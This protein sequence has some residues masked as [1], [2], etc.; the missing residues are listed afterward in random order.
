MTKR[1][2]LLI[3]GNGPAAH[4]LITDLCALQALPES[5]G[6]IGEESRT[7]YNRILLSPLLAAQIDPAQLELHYPPEAQNAVEQI[8]DA[9]VVAINAQLQSVTTESGE[10]FG[11]EQLVIATGARPVI[12]DL[13]GVRARGV[14]AFRSW[15]DV[16]RMQQVAARG[17]RAVVVGGGFLGL[18]AAEGLRKLGMSVTLVHRSG[19]LLNRQLDPQAAALLR[20]EM[21][22]RGLEVRTQEQLQSIQ[23][24]YSQLESVTLSNGERLSA[25]LLVFATGI[26]PNAQLAQTGGL[27]HNRGICVDAQ[28]R[29]SDA[30]IFALGECIE[31]NGNTYGL[32]APIWRQSA[33]LAAT[34]SGV[35]DE[36]MDEAFATQLKVSGVELFSCGEID[37]SKE[38]AF[39]LDA[40][41]GQYRRF[42]FDD[43]RLVGAVMYG[44]TSRGPDVIEA[45]LQRADAD[46]A[47]ALIW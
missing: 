16:E 11:Y 6:V 42:W 47:E 33:V 27:K 26:L 5:V 7:A 8:T 2:E 37:R 29:T 28:M 10:S 15:S 13:E 43:D 44:D 25:D 22:S 20:Y 12:P 21:E 46:R 40:E 45:V 39:Y 4:R 18:E 14:L 38:T 3:I 1:Y 41:L 19:Y 34:L 30:R 17:G 31:F 9:R 23:T 35:S 36:Y 32:V 24:K